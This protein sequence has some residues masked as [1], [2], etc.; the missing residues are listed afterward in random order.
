VADIQPQVRDKL[1]VMVQRVTLTWLRG[2][3]MVGTILL[4]TLVLVGAGVMGSAYNGS[5]GGDGLAPGLFVVTVVAVGVLS[6]VLVAILTAGIHVLSDAR[7]PL[8]YVELGLSVVSITTGFVWWFN[9]G[10]LFWLIIITIGI[11]GLLYIVI[12]SRFMYHAN[13]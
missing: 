7:S 8:D 2:A 13:I 3:A 12:I 10:E 6:G 4:P 1:D 11:V 5:S 9:L